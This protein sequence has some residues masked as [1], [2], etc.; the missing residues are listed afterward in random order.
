MSR[1]KGREA[2][3]QKKQIA[4][5]LRRKHQ[6]QLDQAIDPSDVESRPHKNQQLLLDEF[7]IYKHLYVKAGN[8]CLAKGTLVA[9]PQGP[10]A[11]EDIQ[12]GDIVYNEFGEPIKVVKTFDNGKR[13]VGVL[14]DGDEIP[15]AVCTPDHKWLV[16]GEKRE[17]REFKAT[18]VSR[19]RPTET[20]VLTSV[21]LTFRELD[22][23]MDTYDIQVDSPTHLFLLAN[24]LVTSNSGKSQIAAKLASIFFQHKFNLLPNL[25][26]PKVWSQEPLLILIVGRTNKQ[27]AE[28]IWRK[29]RAFLPPSSYKE[30]NSGGTLQ[31]VESADGMAKILFVSMENPNQAVERIQSYVV[32]LAWVDEIPGSFKIIEELH[33]RTQARDGYFLATFTPKTSN[34]QIRRLV[35][36]ARAPL[37]KTYAFHMFDNPVYEDEQKRQGILD[38]IA[39]YPT[40]FQNTILS[41]DWLSEDNLVFYWNADMMEREAVGYTPNWRHLV[42]DDP[43]HR[44]KH[45]HLVFAESPHTG[46]WYVLRAEYL[47]GTAPSDLVAQV[48]AKTSDI[49]VVRRVVDPAAAAYWTEAQKLGLTYTMPYHKANRKEEMIGKVQEALGRRLFVCPHCVD[50]V[51]ELTSYQRSEEDPKRI[52]ASKKYHLIDALCYGWD[53]IPKFEAGQMHGYDSMDQW[54]LAQYHNRMQGKPVHNPLR[55][56]SRSRR[57]R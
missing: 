45:G 30:L 27:L 38:S 16:N 5:I 7:G 39:H 56:K 36:G 35:D 12:V 13:A 40:A 44:S 9:T 50:L 57:W 47:E 10:V 53:M 31:S 37:A 33:R 46:D 52:I 24:G 54:L 21:A 18:P 29:I 34:P 23:E 43:A 19:F 3:L 2:E 1:L 8:Q 28:N 4:A 32:H 42:S 48:K 11:I 55:I 26:V 51:D 25:Q 20:K 22:I 49:N 15:W 14:L 6:L 41:G 17:A